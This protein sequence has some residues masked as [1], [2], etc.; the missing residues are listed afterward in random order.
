MHKRAAS[1]LSGIFGVLFVWTSVL[2]AQE[3]KYTPPDRGTTS[4]NTR[5]SA[6]TRGVK[7]AAV[8]VRVL[9]PGHEGQTVNEQPTIYWFISREVTLP[10]ELTV[11]AKGQAD[12]VLRLELEQT[13]PAG[14][15][16]LDL[17]VHGVKLKQNM[18]YK[19]R[20]AVMTDS[21]HRSNA[22]IASADLRRIAA[23]VRLLEKTS[24]AS[25]SQAAAVYAKGGLWFDAM[26]S[27]GKGIERNGDR[28]L[29]AARVSLLEQVGL[30]A[31]ADWDRGQL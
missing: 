12:P 15:H 8:T 7:R 3:F 17:A 26:Q 16:A 11:R 24:G 9:A 28:G 5:V 21:R 13:K 30:N 1:V 18:S 20:V 23:D 14:I 25:A 29:R 27:L 22:V 6:G 19:C 4:S 31:I 2:E 10:I